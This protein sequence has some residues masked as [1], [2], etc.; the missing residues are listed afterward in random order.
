MTNYRKRTLSKEGLELFNISLGNETSYQPK[1][2]L[3]KFI[4]GIFTTNLDIEL[5]KSKDNFRNSTYSLYSFLDEDF[6]NLIPDYFNNAITNIIYLILV[7]DNKINTKKQILKN[8]H[9]YY[10]L[11]DIAMKNKDH[12]TAVLLRAVLNNIAIKRLNIKETKKI[13]KIKNKLEQTYGS[14]L[15]CNAKHVE[16]IL[17][18]KD[19]SFLPS[20]LILL[21]HINKTKEYAKAYRSIGK[22]PKELEEKNDKLQKIAKIYYNQFINFRDNLLEVYTTH[23]SKLKLLENSTKRN[24]T[25]KLFE[26]SNMVKN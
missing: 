8:L 26:L 10:T 1:I 17:N 2:C 25:S 16:D 23:P 21:M 24:I 5:E 15:S 12:N 18:N 20:I 22:F 3:K 11:A 14:F 6:I 4:C 13:K 9:F 7:N 19:Q